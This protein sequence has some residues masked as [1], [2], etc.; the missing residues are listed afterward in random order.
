M[1]DRVFVGNEA[2]LFGFVTPDQLNGYIKRVRDALPSRIKVTTAEP[3][4]TWLLTPEIGQYVDVVSVHLLA[5]LGRH[6]GAR[7]A[8]DSSS[9]PTTTCRRSF[10]TSRSSSAKRA[11]RRKAAPS[12][13][14]EPS[15]ANEAYFMR[16]FV[17]LAMEKGYDY[18]LLE[19]L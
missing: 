14:A 15:L 19:G 7:L 4:S 1:I 12:D 11:G 8:C 5:L 6:V 16:A 18:Y 13:F 17:Q 2:I 10:P 9:T 3:W